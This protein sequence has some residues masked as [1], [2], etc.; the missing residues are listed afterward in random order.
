MKILKLVFKNTLRHKLRTALTI[1]GIS[2]AVVAF[3]FLRTVVTAWYAGVEASSPNR[4]ITRNAVSFI[5]PLPLAYRDRIAQIPGVE[6]VAYM[7]WFQGVYIDKSQFFARFAVE[8]ESSLK[9]YPE[10]LVPF[11]QRE[12]LLKERN[13]C[14]VGSD[15]AK[16]YGFKIGDVIPI[17]GDIFPGRWEFVVR[18]IYQP[19]DKTVDG[20]Q[21]WFHWQYL[22][23]RMKQEMP[24]RA[25]EVGWYIVR[26]SHPDDAA[27]ISQQVDEFFK[28]SRAETKTETEAAFQQSFV[29]GTGLIIQLL[30]FLSFVIIGIIMLVLGNT[31]IMSA[32]ERTREYAV[33]KTL[34][35]SGG[36][37]VSLIAGESL[38]I[39]VLGAV[40]GLLLTL[41]L[42]EMFSLFVPKSW[43]P[44]FYVE[45]ITYVLAGASAL[46]VG[47]VSALFPIQR[48]VKT[49]IVEG[50]R[51]V[52]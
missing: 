21:M 8:M 35:F 42:V 4:L 17:E 26:F 30:N 52:G 24:T 48:A 22:D 10:F 44:V 33:L 9:A 43:F 2:I 49:T 20:T 5:F 32:R 16:Q 39:S 41:P 23:E 3:G 34:G 27:K 1:L 28:N 6:T 51:F 25:G 29:A 11:D 36:S 38:I 40:I 18:A 12:V 7:N 46:F 45:P 37:L 13:A 31:M 19:R 15:L 47:I 50:L 14:L